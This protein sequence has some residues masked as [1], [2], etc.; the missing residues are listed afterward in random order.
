MSH[1]GYQPQFGLIHHRRL[2][3]GADGSDLRGHD[4]LEG[5]GGKRFAIR[6]HLHPQ[7][8]RQ[9]RP[10]RPGGA[11]APAE[12]RRLPPAQPGRRSGI[13]ETGE[14]ALGESVYLG[15]RGE[16]RR[17]QQVVVTGE[18]MGAGAEVKWQLTRENRRK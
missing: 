15:R 16:P 3:L 1:D 6:F 2:F 5:K 10:G 18:L 8:D 7:V 14:V 9:P 12:R 13:A 17:S 4:R 11:A